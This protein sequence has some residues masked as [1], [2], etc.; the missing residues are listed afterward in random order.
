MKLGIFFLQRRPVQ[1]LRKPCVTLRAFCHGSGGILKQGFKKVLYF[2]PTCGILGIGKAP[3]PKVDASQLS[4]SLIEVAYPVADRIG[5]FYFLRFLLS[6]KASNATIKL[7]KETIRLVIP[8]NI[9]MISEAVM[10]TTSLP[11]YSGEP[12]IKFGRLPPCHG[13]FSVIRI[14]P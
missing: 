14:L 9:M 3:T 10:C 11:M 4:V 7:P 8:I 6:R 2:C 1:P 5:I 12:V 13:Y